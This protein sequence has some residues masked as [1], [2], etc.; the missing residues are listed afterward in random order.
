MDSDSEPKIIKQSNQLIEKFTT[1]DEM[2]RLIDAKFIQIKQEESRL[3]RRQQK[4]VKMSASKRKFL[5]K[6]HSLKRQANIG[7]IAIKLSS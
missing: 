6:L 3:L 1:E 4:Q 7:T 5:K 2:N